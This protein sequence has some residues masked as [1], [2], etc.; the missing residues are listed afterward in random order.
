MRK[1]ADLMEGNAEH[2]ADLEVADN[3]KLKAEMLVQMKYL[4]Q[5]F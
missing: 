5:W 2:L 1:L 4:P 3:G